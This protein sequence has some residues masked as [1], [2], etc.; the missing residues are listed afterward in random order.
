MVAGSGKDGLLLA[1]EHRPKGIFLDL[2]LP[3]M[4]GVDVLEQLKYHIHTKHIPVHV[5]SG[6]DDALETMQRGAVGFMPKPASEA[7]VTAVLGKISD[8]TAR[9]IKDILVV[10]DNHDNQRAISQLIENKGV[11]VSCVDNG[12]EAITQISTGAYDCV[13]LDIGL[14][15]ITGFEVLKRLSA[16]KKVQIPPVI[17]YTGQELTEEERK[18]LQRYSASIVLKGAESPEKL[19]DEAMLFMHSI[20][21]DLSASQKKTIYSLHDEAKLLDQRKALLVDD[22]MRNTFALSK[23]LHQVGLQGFEADNG[24]TALDKLDEE[25]DVELII[26]DIMMPIMDGYEAMR[27]IRKIPHLKNI[28]I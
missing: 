15:D 17:V 6:S 4:D 16:D 1:L 26:M 2:G 28:P 8:L 25:H 5:I 3:D 11:T 20:T 24:Q 14:P 23:S 27:R 22:D 21:A 19:L 18:E 13:V 7:D 9:D 10:E 12:E